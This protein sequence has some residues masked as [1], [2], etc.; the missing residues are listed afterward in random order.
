M[1]QQPAVVWLGAACPR[2]LP[3]VRSGIL[4]MPSRLSATF[5]AGSKSLFVSPLEQAYGTHGL[6]LLFVVEEVDC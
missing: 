4:L 2:Q 5:L 1:L 6:E 3:G